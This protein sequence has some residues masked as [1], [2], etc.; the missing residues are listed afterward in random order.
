[1]KMLLELLHGLG[2]GMVGLRVVNA[3]CDDSD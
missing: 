2:S 3:T 1:M